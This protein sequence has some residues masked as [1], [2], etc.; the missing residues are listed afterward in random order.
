MFKSWKKYVLGLATIF[1][2]GMIA[3]P[4]AAESSTETP[5]KID[6][7]IGI[8]TRYT[9][10]PWFGGEKSTIGYKPDKVY[11]EVAATLKFTTRQETGIGDITAQIG[12]FFGKTIGDDFYG[13]TRTNRNNLWELAG[14]NSETK[15]AHINQA[16]L[17]LENAF[18]SSFDI[19]VGRQDIYIEKG[20]IF[21]GNLSNETATWLTMNESFPM[22]LR[23]DHKIGDL[24]STL[25]WAQAEKYNK[26][27]FE[28]DVHM[29]GVNLH[30]DL[31]ENAYFYGSVFKKDEPSLSK[32]SSKI[33]TVENDTVSYNLGTD[34]KIGRVHFE[35]EGAYQTGDSKTATGNNDR[36]SYAYWGAATY[37]FDATYS[38]YIRGTYLYF[39]GEDA[40][41]DKVEGY[42]PMFAGFSGWNRFVIG[43]FVGENQ[44]FN[45]NRESIVLEVGMSPQPALP[46]ALMFIRN[47]LAEADASGN[48]HWADE[49]N[50][51]ADYFIGDNIY[52]HGAVGYAIPGDAAKAA[53]G[54]DKNGTFAHVQ[55]KYS[56]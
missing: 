37:N 18:K 21:W 16:W 44:I 41:T 45:T 55:I 32:T 26:G 56:F 52:L 43:E 10:N 13:I 22:A 51:I 24:S 1:S 33:D 35:L 12:G 7:K 48:K 4:C 54:D 47:N 27:G 15:V 11:S 49:I 6:G 42:D 50:L 19:T 40:G 9:S 25:V 14:Y 39:A 31:S 23:V 28:D 46:L 8:F 34:Y 2:I 20:F 29:Y 30:Y 53:Y 36:E 3:L 38:P 17:K 5:V